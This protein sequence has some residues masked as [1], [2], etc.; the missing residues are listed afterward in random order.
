MNSRQQKKKGYD[1]K[2]ED[3][4]TAI[5]IVPDPNTGEIQ[6]KKYRNIK[7]ATRTVADFEK[8]IQKTFPTVTQINYYGG[9][10]HN[11]LRKTTFCD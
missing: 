2:R 1:Y 8:F 6:G 10:S 9:L 3:L 11:F 4:L 7:D 5:A